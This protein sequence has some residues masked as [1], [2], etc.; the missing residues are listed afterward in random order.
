MILKIALRNL[1]AAPSRSLMVGL[2]IFFCSFL[3]FTGT[4]FLKTVS[5]HLSENYREHITGD[6]II[7]PKG[8]DSNKGL[9]RSMED[10]LIGNYPALDNVLSKMNGIAH[11]LGQVSGMVTLSFDEKGKAYVFAR[12]I[13]PAAYQSSFPHSLNLTIGRFI[14]STT[15]GFLL[16]KTVAEN[17]KQ[18]L[19]ITLKPGDILKLS[20]AGRQGVKIRTL[21]LA[22]IITYATS[23][24]EK[25]GICLMDSTTLLTLMGYERAMQDAAIVSN[26]EYKDLMEG[27]FFSSDL[28]AAA[29]DGEEEGETLEQLFQSKNMPSKKWEEQRDQWH[30]VLV[31]LKNPK[32][33]NEIIEQLNSLFAER[34]WD[35]SAS[36][37]EI[38][39]GSMAQ[40]SRTFQIIFNIIMFLLTI[41]TIIVITNTLVV[42]VIGRTREIGT[43]RAL[44]SYKSFIR[45]L[46]LSETMILAI[47]SGTAGILLGMGTVGV[48]S[49]I[50][51]EMKNDLLMLMMG[52]YRIYPQLQGISF[53]LTTAYMLLIGFLSSLYPVQMALKV[54]PLTAIQ[55]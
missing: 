55:D 32:Q 36:N 45:K 7:Q 46:F 19:G 10:P 27:D 24:L 54:S 38:A 3:I 37:W 30:Y 18:E 43:M 44:G 9:D 4:S 12:G 15:P 33:T 40:F 29:S 21:P 22:G 1:Y 35:L 5:S 25:Q 41:V 6:I 13:Q 47:I 2:L 50:G 11:Y 49:K 8:E 42:A 17:I 34:G 53:S 23:S 31:K 39:A 20:Y 48:V 28:V 16:S 26:Q 52:D 51:V 14:D